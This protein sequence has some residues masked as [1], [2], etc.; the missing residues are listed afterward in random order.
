M[1][2]RQKWGSHR[3]VLVAA[4]HLSVSSTMIRDRVAAGLPLRYL[5]P[6]AVEEFVREHALYRRP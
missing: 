3:I 5:V 4:P 1:R 2:A 6:L